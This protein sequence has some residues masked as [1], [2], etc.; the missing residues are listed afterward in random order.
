MSILGQRDQQT[1]Y[2]A[3]RCGAVRPASTDV[4]PQFMCCC[5][6][7]LAVANGCTLETAVE[8]DCNETPDDSK[9]ITDA[10]ASGVGYRVVTIDGEWHG[11]EYTTCGAFATGISW[12]VPGGAPADGA[13]VQKMAITYVDYI[14][15]EINDFECDEGDT[16]TD[17]YWE[18]WPV[19]KNQEIPAAPFHFDWWA[20]G[21]SA[22]DD[23]SITWVGQASYYKASEMDGKGVDDFEPGVVPQAI[24]LPATFD[25]PDFWTDPAKPRVERKLTIDWDCNCSA[26]ETAE[27][28]VVCNYHNDPC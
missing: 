21:R 12:Q 28:Q 18:M 27:T 8:A 22:S 7:I 13:I 14:S 17:T 4:I 9:C 15:Y 23:G 2:S 10:G 5:A 26:D 6:L 24:D 3:V 19:F 1:N 20:S 25:E 11:G 16:R